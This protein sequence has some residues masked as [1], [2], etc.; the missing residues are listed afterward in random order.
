[1]VTPETCRFGPLTVCP[2]VPRTIPIGFGA[3]ASSGGPLGLATDPLTGN[4]Y[5]AE[6]RNGADM[7]L[8]IVDSATGSRSPVGAM[9][10]YSQI[11]GLTF[12]DT[13][14]ALGT[15]Y[16]SPAIPN[17]TGVPGSISAVGQ[18][19]IAAN[20]VTLTADQLPAD[21][22]SFLNSMT[23]GLFSPPNSFGFVCLSGA[24]CR[25]YQPGLVGQGPTFSITLDLNAIPTP[26]AFVA[27]QPGDTWNFQAWY[28]DLGGTN[29]FTDAVAVTF[30]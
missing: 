27:I 28:R 8:A 17:S 9:T 1:M 23:Q 19:S 16:C 20:D 18:T 3:A 30:Q 12:L 7:T 4:L 22:G 26:T 6:W 21:F 5:V 24:I 25:H 13:T 10:G 29:N 2:N 11:E 14:G 15:T